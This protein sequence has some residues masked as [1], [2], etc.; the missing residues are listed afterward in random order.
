MALITSITVAA[1]GD[2]YKRSQSYEWPTDPLVVRKLKQWQDLKLGVL[3]HWGLYA[4]PGI[5]ESWSICD[6]NWISR[7]TTKSGIGGC[8][9]SSIPH[10]LNLNNGPQRLRMQV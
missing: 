2:V 6:E 9:S 3:I 7:D 5:V 4:V 1:Q 10:D 8:A